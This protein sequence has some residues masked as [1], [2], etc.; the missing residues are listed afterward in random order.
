MVPANLPDC[1]PQAYRRRKQGTM[2]LIPATSI[3]GTVI[4]VPARHCD[5]E[6]TLAVNQGHC[7]FDRVPCFTAGGRH[8]RGQADRTRRPHRSGNRRGE[9]QSGSTRNSSLCSARDAS[10]SR[11]SAVTTFAVHEKQ[12]DQYRHHADDIDRILSIDLPHSR[13]SPAIDSKIPGHREYLPVIGAS[14]AVH[15]PASATSPPWQKNDR[16]PGG[17]GDSCR[18]APGCECRSRAA[19]LPGSLRPPGLYPVAA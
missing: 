17:P 16:T 5:P 3:Q 2:T 12:S 7:P 11:I 10:I 13:P 15:T 1:R 9:I 4:L 19:G 14:V 18:R 6:R 8:R